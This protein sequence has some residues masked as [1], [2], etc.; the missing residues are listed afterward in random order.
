[1]FPGRS[2]T[3]T[4]AV[5]VPRSRPSATTSAVSSITSSRFEPSSCSLRMSSRAS[6]TSSRRESRRFWS[7]SD[8]SESPT[9]TPS[10][11]PIPS[12]KKTATSDSAW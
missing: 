12:A 5:L 9:V 2:P 7:A 11:I 4:R 10:T 6:V 3:A 1:M 8:T